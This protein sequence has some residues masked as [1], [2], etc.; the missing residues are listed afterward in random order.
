[1]N[2][3]AVHLEIIFT[4]HGFELTMFVWDGILHSIVLHICLACISNTRRE[5]VGAACVD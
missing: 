4:F 1:M 3:S 5:Y 2:N